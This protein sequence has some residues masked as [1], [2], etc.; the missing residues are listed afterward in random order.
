M[1]GAYLDIDFHLKILNA[2][3]GYLYYDQYYL[4]PLMEMDGAEFVCL[5]AFLLL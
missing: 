1:T 4:A 3:E 2:L 5:F